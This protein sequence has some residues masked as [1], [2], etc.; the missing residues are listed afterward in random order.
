MATHSVLSASGAKKW[1]NCNG[2]P[3]MEQGEPDSGSRFADEGTAAHY[4]GATCL[5]TGA[6]ARGYE[7]RYIHVDEHGYCVLHPNDGIQCARCGA[8]RQAHCFPVD[9]EMVANVQ[10]YIDYVRL[11]VG[12]GVSM[13]EQRVSLEHITGETGGGGTADAIILNGATLHIIDLKYG[14]GVVVSAFENEQLSLYALGAMELLSL[15]EDIDAITTVRLHIVQPRISDDPNVY[16]VTPAALHEFAKRVSD[17]AVRCHT[18][19]ALQEEGK[20]ID[21]YL[22]PSEGACQ[23]CKAKA[24]CPALATLVQEQVGEQFEDMDAAKADEAVHASTPAT[25]AVKM[26]KVGLIE[27]WCKAIRAKTFEVLQSGTPVPGFKLVKGRA[28]NRAW[29]NPDQAEA[30]LKSMRIKHDQM[31][32]YRIISPTKAEKLAEQDLIGKRQWPKLQALIT[33]ADGSPSVAPES[34]KRP[35]RE[36][37]Q[38]DVVSIN[39]GDSNE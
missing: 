39:Q 31:Y 4:L 6:N 9:A 34:D 29:S 35:A 33:R 15:T 1:L 23:W 22:N 16:E 10:A 17:A 21:S 25:L 36:V 13:V 37:V 20:P 7:G 26:A 28:G 27:D 30:M 32:D 19:I 5:E 8:G 24:K 2:A 3:A 38:F 14:R 18:A 11:R 12:N